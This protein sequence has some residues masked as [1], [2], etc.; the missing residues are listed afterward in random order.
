MTDQGIPRDAVAFYQELLLNNNK[1][2]WDANKDR[3][4]RSVRE[5]IE[6]IAETL[7]EEFDADV[8]LFRPHRDV[9]FSAD[10]TPY[11][12]QQAVL[13]SLGE[14]LGWYFA[15]DATGLRTGAGFMG[16]SGAR[17]NSFRQ[18]VDDEKSGAALV[19]LMKRFNSG[20]VIVQGDQLKTVP[21]G[22]PID[23]PRIDLLR[24]KSIQVICDHGTPQW[25]SSPDVVE[26][27][28]NDWQSFSDFVQWLAKY[29]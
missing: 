17:V 22:F 26:Q 1:T 5:P 25:L 9:R 12:T 27:I 8:R 14:G 19:A 7:A 28:R 11:K 29:L 6:L 16:G 15:V 23:H 3:Y 4:R 24:Y 20:D 21:R 10:K 2:W 13:L 18:A